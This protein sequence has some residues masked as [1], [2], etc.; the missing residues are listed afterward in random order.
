MLRSIRQLIGYRILAVDGELGRAEDFYFD[1]L[2][3][4]IRYLVASVERTLFGR[5][6]LISPASVKEPDWSRH[7]IPVDLTVQQ[8]RDSPDIDTDLPVSRQQEAKLAE[9][10]EWPLW[11]QAPGMPFLY[12]PMAAGG[13]GAEEARPPGDPHLRSVVEVT[14]YGVTAS[15]GNIGRVDDFIARTADWVIRHVEVK[16]R[17]W[18][19]GRRV[20][21]SPG[22]LERVDWGRRRI[23][24]GLTR[25]EIKASPAFDPSARCS[26]PRDAPPAR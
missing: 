5:K 16:T 21:V 9:H 10:Y 6:V 25:D 22:S 11:W 14:T 20:L 13:V 4:S 2:T 19:P 23:Y 3:W 17:K 26:S 1:D 8:V 24:M 7:V 18:L 15:D 12:V